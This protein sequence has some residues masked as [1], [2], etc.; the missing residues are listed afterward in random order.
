MKAFRHWVLDNCHIRQTGR[1]LTGRAVEMCM[2]MMMTFFRA[3]AS[4]E[5][6]FIDARSVFDPVQNARVLKGAKR[7][8]NRNA[9]SS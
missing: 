6:I 1:L 4:T 9:V 5:C 3:V 8:I 2:L 7:A